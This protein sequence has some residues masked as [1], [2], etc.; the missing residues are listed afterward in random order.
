MPKQPMRDVVVL[1]PGILGSALAR[2]GKEVWAPT[3]G[4][5]GRALW[6]LGHSVKD[7]EL[8]D[9]PWEVDDI[10]DGVTATRLMPDVHIVPGL[11]GIDGYSGISKM[12]TARFDLVPGETYLEF[13]Y[14]W[15]RDNRV[16]ARALRRVADEKLH[17]ARQRDP[18]AKLILIG[19]SMGGLVARY[20]LECLDGWKDTRML[21]TFGTPHRGSLNAVDF[22]TNG[23]VKK[24]G[25]LKIADLTRLLRSLTSVYQLLPTYPC[26]D[27]GQGGE[28]L[29]VADASDSL[30]GVDAARARA[31]ADDFHGA[32]DAGVG[33]HEQ[34]VYD[35]HS[36]VGITQG[37]K[38]SVR[39]DGDKVVCEELYKG[40]DLGG[41][42]TVPRLSAT[43]A[44]TDGWHPVYQPMYSAD[45]H[46]AA[47][48]RRS[49]ADTAVRH[50]HGGTDRRDSVVPRGA[51]RGAGAARPRREPDG[52]CAPRRRQ[53]DTA[54]QR[55]RPRHRPRR[56]H[57]A[58][59]QPRRRRRSSRRG[60]PAP[61]G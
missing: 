29:L 21:I 37:T 16:A 50:P 40:T 14:D 57:A 34:G 56:R 55:H 6:S 38:Q 52:A 27:L 48:E 3:P 7:L 28:Y 33:G 30:A 54:R 44:E 53:P 41:D 25:P 15:R 43:P 5:I 24:L 12:I 17:A 32:I 35:L 31:A 51:S 8:K 10:G 58:H 36:V 2:E 42:G 59:A 61:G 18:D 13:P 45:R 1:L 49:G 39:L 9:D 46:A 19:H 22:L 11:W 60:P 4:A 47:A 20:F 23:F 26:V